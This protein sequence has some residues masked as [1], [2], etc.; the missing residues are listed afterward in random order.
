MAFLFCRNFAAYAFHHPHKKHCAKE[1]SVD[2]AGFSPTKSNFI[3]SSKENDRSSEGALTCQTQIV[4]PLCRG[5][6]EKELRLSQP[7]AM[8]SPTLSRKH[9]LRRHVM[10]L[11][12]TNSHWRF[13]VAMTHHGTTVLIS[14]AKISRTIKNTMRINWPLNIA[15]LRATAAPTS[16]S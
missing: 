14:Y 12:E 4:L 13:P 1:P 9:L 3:I 8:F 10:N 16:S 15:C 5:F 11:L 6:L 2:P 7:L